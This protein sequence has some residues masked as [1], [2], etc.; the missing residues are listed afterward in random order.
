MVS[1]FKNIKPSKPECEGRQVDVKWWINSDKET[2]V[3]CA[4]IY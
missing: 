3:S 1:T 4:I 2:E